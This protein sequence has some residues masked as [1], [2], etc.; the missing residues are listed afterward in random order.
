[1]PKRIDARLNRIL[2]NLRPRT[3]LAGQFGPPHS[4]TD[5][6]AY[7]HTPGVSVAVIHDFEVEWARGFGRRAARFPHKV[8][9]QTLFQA[10]SISKPVFALAVMRL[11]EAG[12][13]DLDVDIAHYLTAWRVPANA[14]WRPK[15]TL[16]HILSHTAGFTVHG[17]PGYQASERLPTL[18]QI[19]AG[20]A[21]A[22]TPKVE[23]NLLPGTQFRYSGGGF[24]VAQQLLVDVLQQP[25][26]QIM[27]ELVLEPF[28]MANS[29]FEQPLPARW[30]S[31]AATAHPSKG[32]PTKGRFHTYPEMAA[33]G[34]WTTAA[35]LA[36]LG[37]R[38]LRILHGQDP[39]GPLTSATVA[40]MLRP[41]LAEQAVGA[42]EFVGLG[43]FCNGQDDA[44]SF[45]HSGGNEGFVSQLHVYKNT[46]QGAVVMV[47]SN[48]GGGLMDEIFRAIGAEYQWPPEPSQPKPVIHL[49]APQNYV[50]RY[51][52]KTAAPIEI[53][54]AGDQLMLQYG[55][56]PALR[57]F[58]TSDVEFFAKAI[59]AAIRFERDEHGA[60][61]S[62]ILTQEGRPIK[63]D[64]QAA[65]D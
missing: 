15:I 17:F 10:A 20:A 14:G 8:N 45:G 11:V 63:A 46:G 29:T 61:V 22:N 35:D 54:L 51:L 52:S 41:Q 49:A 6:M 24:S 18:P 56:Q 23:V 65:A 38:L 5:R 33:A 42:T 37:V 59:N 12:Q 3:G 13:L 16:R 58:P 2:G 43:F 39:A 31:R 57:I 4:L 21:P 55:L 64:R 26:P 36:G 7:Y 25:F 28:A 48:E 32:I 47:N 34:L 40:A 50:G 62:L 9:H 44:F 60:V 30:A 53:S 1:M 19:L 27:R